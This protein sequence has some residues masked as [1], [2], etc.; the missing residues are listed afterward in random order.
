MVISR[1]ACATSGPVRTGPFF[2]DG[3]GRAFHRMHPDRAA[4]WF[5]LLV[6]GFQC[7]VVSFLTTDN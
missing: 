4:D 2:F 7:S 6:F 5:I 3:S 1:A